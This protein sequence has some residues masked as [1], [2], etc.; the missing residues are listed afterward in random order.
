MSIINNLALRYDHLRLSAALLRTLRYL[1]AA[2]RLTGPPAY[3]H[4][5]TH[6]GTILL[7]AAKRVT[8][9]NIKCYKDSPI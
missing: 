7:V 4:P 6:I 8:P 9:R 1:A 3:N 5:N 2:A